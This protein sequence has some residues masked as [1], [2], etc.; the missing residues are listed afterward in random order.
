[1][2][3]S[4]K[5]GIFL[6]CVCK[7][8]D[9]PEARRRSLSGIS[10]L[11]QHWELA[12]KQYHVLISAMTAQELRQRLDVIIKRFELWHMADTVQFHQRRIRDTLCRLLT[13]RAI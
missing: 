8:P 11:Q 9:F 12:S 10:A 2:R 6:S 3:K 4:Y 7:Q 13:Q 1:M 5:R